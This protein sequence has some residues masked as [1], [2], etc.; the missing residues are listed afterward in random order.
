MKIITEFYHL[1][2]MGMHISNFNFDINLA[3][4][5]GFE[6][7]NNLWNKIINCLWIG[8]NIDGGKWVRVE[9]SK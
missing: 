1:N 4:D 8:L 9:F 2:C 5:S 6:F 7:Q 3:V